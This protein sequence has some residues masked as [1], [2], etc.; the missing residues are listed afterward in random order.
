MF[1]RQSERADLSLLCRWCMNSL[2]EPVSEFLDESPA[3]PYSTL[4][5][6]DALV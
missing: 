1:I 3:N 4:K 6:F 5:W 2:L